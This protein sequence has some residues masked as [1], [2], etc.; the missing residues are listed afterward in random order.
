MTIDRDSSSRRFRLQL[1]HPERIEKQPPCQS[2]CP[3]SGDIRAWI[4]VVAQ[5]HRTGMSETEACDAAWRI[6]VD[7]N[8][9]PAT[10]G[11]ICP[12]PCESACNRGAKDGAVSVNAMERF[13]GD[14][15]IERGLALERLG[16]ERHEES[17][18]VIGAGPAGLSFAYQ[19][20]RRGYR[21]TVYDAHETPGGMLTFGIPAYRLPKEVVDAEVQRIADLG[22]RFDCGVRV[23]ADVGIDS[24]RERHQF[25]FVGIG[26]QAS[27]SLGIEGEAGPGVLSGID[28]L[29]QVQRGELG[30]LGRDV[31][32]IGGGNTAVDAARTAR[33]TGASVSMLY[34]RTRSEMPAFAEEV[35]EAVEEGVELVELAAPEAF[36]RMDGRL[37]A[38]AVQRMQLG[39]T[40]SDGRREPLP[41][42][43]DTFEIPSTT[44]IVAVSQMSRW[45]GLEALHSLMEGP[46]TLHDPEATIIEGGDVLRPGIA[47]A[48]IGQ[49]RSAA[50]HAHAR[51]RGHAPPAPPSR[52]SV[53]PELLRLDVYPC[54]ERAEPLVLD[55][56]VRASDPQREVHL[57]I[58]RSQFLEEAERCFS[59]GSCFGC[60]RCA[61]YCN[62]CGYAAVEQ[63]RP[64]AYFEFSPDVCEGCGKC[65]EL[66]PCGFIGLHPED[67]GLRN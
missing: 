30:D 3:G 13:L 20:A 32:V 16:G 15:G 33:R 54:A 49:G 18:G 43:G 1:L 52:P 62:P 41:I 55:S 4:G 8:P 51:L 31:V 40:G 29:A 50:E 48:A 61:M 36:L 53:G 65:I 6:L 27:R 21:V 46:Q 22:V 39:P 37:R 60:G 9:L 5:R 23:G 12:H 67:S 11:R 34:R 64:G 7:R 17:I 58:S 47:S 56:Q 19:M 38:V 14:W 28:Y 25:V 24:L 66:C 35:N 59:C 2:G 45:D 57:G 10:M 26:A 42:P 63:P 44:A